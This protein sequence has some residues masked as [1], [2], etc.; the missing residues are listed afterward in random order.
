V[1]ARQL[2][3]AEFLGAGMLRRHGYLFDVARTSSGACVVRAWPWAHGRTGT[4]AFVDAPGNALASHRNHDGR[5]SGPE[6][7]PS[8]DTSANDGW[9]TLA[10]GG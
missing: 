3:D 7:P 8:A 9:K 5:W 1:L 2:D 6:H 10:S 4:T